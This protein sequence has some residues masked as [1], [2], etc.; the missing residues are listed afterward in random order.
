M[1]NNINNW[2]PIEE[3][4]K[5]NECVVKVMRRLKYS[6]AFS[7]GS[8]AMMPTY[9]VSIAVSSLD[10]E[11]FFL[12]TRLVVTFFAQRLFSNHIRACLSLSLGGHVYNVVYEKSNFAILSDRQ[13]PHG[14]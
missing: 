14:F 11:A 8:T 3:K 4:A 2:Y 9:S 5:S 10:V 1:I 13:D 12:V 7:I 6:V